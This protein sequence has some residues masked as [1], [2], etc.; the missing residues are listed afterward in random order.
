MYHVNLI[1]LWIEL[2]DSFWAGSVQF[3]V[4]NNPSYM[5]VYYDIEFYGRSDVICISYLLAE[6]LELVK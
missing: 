2:T 1:A 6:L 5:K 3:E 4:N